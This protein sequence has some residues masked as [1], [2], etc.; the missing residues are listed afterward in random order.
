MNDTVW[1]GPL[2]EDPKEQPKE[3]PKPEE[4]EKK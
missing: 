4:Q 3:D 1:M 2:E